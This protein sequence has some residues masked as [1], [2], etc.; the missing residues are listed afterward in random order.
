[1][2]SVTSPA[3]CPHC[4]LVLIVGM[5]HTCTTYSDG[6]GNTNPPARYAVEPYPWRSAPGGHK[7]CPTCR[8]TEEG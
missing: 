8:C 1:M 5:V 3:A 7:H 4:G 6:S 2:M